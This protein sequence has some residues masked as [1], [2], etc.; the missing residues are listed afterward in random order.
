MEALPPAET[1]LHSSPIHSTAGMEMRSGEPT[2][3]AAGGMATG[4][5]P[6]REPSDAA[7]DDAAAAGGAR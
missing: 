7:A 2:E 1:P 5:G 4:A 6:E 3:R